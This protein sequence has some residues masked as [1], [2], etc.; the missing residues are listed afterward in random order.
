[1]L[2]QEQRQTLRVGGRS[3]RAVAVVFAAVRVA[4]ARG[5]AAAVRVVVSRVVR[6]VVARVFARAVVFARV[7]VE[8]LVAPRHERC[9]IRIRVVWLHRRVWRARA[10]G[11]KRVSAARCGA[12]ASLLAALTYA[13]PGELHKL[14]SGG[15]FTP[16]R[17]R[18]IAAAA[19]ARVAEYVAGGVPAPPHV[20]RRRDAWAC[21]S[22]CPTLAQTMSL[23]RCSSFALSSTRGLHLL[24]LAEGAALTPI[25]SWPDAMPMSWCLSDSISPWWRLRREVLASADTSFTRGRV[26]TLAARDANRRVLSVCS[27]CGTPGFTVTR[28]APCAFPPSEG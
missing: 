26:R 12:A 6:A 5:A 4:V 1:M 24:H 7:A 8:V 22:L 9:A 13:V 27:V 20:S 15:A 10:R 2:S 23:R 25:S 19:A 17:R 18:F 16:H 28:I 21:A 3:H 11:A 14:S